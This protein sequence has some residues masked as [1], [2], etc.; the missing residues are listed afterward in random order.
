MSRQKEEIMRYMEHTYSA[1]PEYLWARYPEY[2]VF[3]RA[4]N[5]KWFAV[6]MSVPAERV[7]LEGAGMVELLNVKCDPAVIG[8]LRM[9]AGYAP[10]YHMNKTS[11]ISIVLNGTVPDREVEALI[12]LS[13]DLVAPKKRK[14]GSPDFE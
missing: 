14:K 13:Y 9:N 12:G 8:S 3:R 10:A 1:S 7:G 11:W 2:A 6:V 5:Q 4:E